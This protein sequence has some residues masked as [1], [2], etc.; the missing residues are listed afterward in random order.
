MKKYLT[1]ILLITPMIAFA[2]S[3]RNLTD[4]MSM[5]FDLLN[6]AA[7]VVGALALLFFFWGLAQLIFHAD[8]EDKKKSSKSIMMWGI[9]ILF[10]MFSISGIL[11]MLDDTFFGGTGSSKSGSSSIFGGPRSGSKSDSN[12]VKLPAD[13]DTSERGDFKQDGKPYFEGLDQGGRLRVGPVIKTLPSDY[14][15]EEEHGGLKSIKTPTG[16]VM[17]DYGGNPS[18]GGYR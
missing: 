5:F 3:P 7:V 18:G 15:P 4:L 14:P 2:A 1:I 16:D 11:R 8:S 10:I 17:D 13:S 12:S 6:Q 9:I